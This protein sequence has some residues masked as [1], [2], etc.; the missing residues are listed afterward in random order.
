MEGSIL[1]LDEICALK[2]KYNFLLFV[3]EAHS[4]GSLGING[5][6]INDYYDYKYTDL[7]DCFMGTFTKSFSAVGGYF[8]SSHEIIKTIREKSLILQ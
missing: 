7:V 3:D 2:E 6:G 1:K 8:C 4:I 5:G